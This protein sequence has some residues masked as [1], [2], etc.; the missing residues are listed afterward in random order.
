[1]APIDKIAAAL[2][3]RLNTLN[4]P[5]HWEN[6]PPYTPPATTAYLKESFL[7]GE[8]MPFG[9]WQAD[10][11]GGI[12]QVTVMAKKGSTKGGSIAEVDAVLGAFPRGVRLAH[13]GQSVTVLTSW[14]SGG[15]ESGD[16]WAVPIS[17]RFRGVA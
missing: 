9:I 11:L 10:I 6:G 17:I 3:T 13:D 14:R 5:T 2:A 7:P 1:M 4:L 12:Y 16:R 8:A 15:F